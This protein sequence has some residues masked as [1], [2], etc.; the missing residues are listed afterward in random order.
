MPKKLKVLMCASEAVPFAKTGGLADVMGSLPQALEELGLEIKLVLPKYKSPQITSDLVVIGKNISVHF[1]E[2]DKFFLRDALYGDKNGDYPDNLERFSFFCRSTLELIK[3]INFKPDIIHVHDWQAALVPIYLKTI[4]KDD[5]FFKRI[6][7]IFTVHNLGYQGLF[8]KEQ[9]P[10]SGLSWD[11]FTVEGL[12]FYDKINLLKGGLIFSDFITTVS[13][14]Y[15]KEIQTKEFGYGLEGLLQKRKNNLFGIVN[16]IDYAV[17]NPQ[18]DTKIFK[19]YSADTLEDKYVNKE[20]LQE[21][22]K[23][24]KAKN[25]ALIGMISRLVDH[26]GFDLIIEVIDQILKLDTQLILLASGEPKYHTFFE[27]LAKKYKKNASINLKY[28]ALLAQKIYAASD[29]FLMPSKY[30]PC[31][32][33]QLIALKYGSIPVVRATGGLKDTII[34]FDSDCK[35]G[36]GF[37]FEEYNSPA[38]LKTVKRALDSY[39]NKKTW[40]QLVRQAMGY[41]YSWGAS[42][43]EYVKLYQKLI[44]LK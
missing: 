26:K 13:P 16:G 6:K 7:T 8:P 27:N 28:D 29:I 39:H 44:G 32:L 37:V 15:S 41:N 20:K 4:F 17:W 2:N 42:A 38:L 5:P 34:D 43:R 30:E 12:E 24:S 31:G 11:I 18:T 19:A 35:K 25:S 33:G 23:L 36:N 10:K 1:I 40:K 9:L 21:E 22:V 3:K 14:T